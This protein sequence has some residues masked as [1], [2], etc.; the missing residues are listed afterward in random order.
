MLATAVAF[1]SVHYRS[2]LLRDAQLRNMAVILLAVCFALVSIPASLG[3]VL[4]RERSC[5]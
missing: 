5:R 4:A 2:T 1:V 3:S